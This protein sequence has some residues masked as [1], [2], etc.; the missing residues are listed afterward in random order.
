MVIIAVNT[1]TE[2][3]AYLS[4]SIVQFIND[5]FEKIASVVSVIRIWLFMWNIFILQGIGK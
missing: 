4:T 3:S 2:L 5:F 1:E